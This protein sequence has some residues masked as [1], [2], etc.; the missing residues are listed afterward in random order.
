[1]TIEQLIQVMREQGYTLD[2]VST[3]IGADSKYSARFFHDC[4]EVCDECEGSIPNEW[5]DFSHANTMEEVVLVAMKALGDICPTV[6]VNI[7]DT[8]SAAVENTE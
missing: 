7:E 4:D 2:L 8:L 3:T 6:L 5:A 1:M